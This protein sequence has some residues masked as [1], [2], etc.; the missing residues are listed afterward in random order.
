M[1]ARKRT[2]V[3]KKSPQGEITSRQCARSKVDRLHVNHIV[4]HDTGFHFDD[5]V[6]VLVDLLGGSH[7]LFRA[8]HEKMRRSAWTDQT[9]R[10]SKPEPAAPD[11]QILMI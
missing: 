2:H 5:P 8:N 10:C 7:I 3:I 6:Q 9:K 1:S 4:Q 11:D